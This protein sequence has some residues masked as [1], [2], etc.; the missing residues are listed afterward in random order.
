MYEVIAVI[1]GK[2]VLVETVDNIVT[3]SNL[4]SFYRTRGQQAY[5]RAVLKRVA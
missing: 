5:Y 4:C 2:E 1:G 3:A